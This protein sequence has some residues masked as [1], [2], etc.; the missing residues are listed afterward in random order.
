MVEKDQAAV[1]VIPKRI[2]NM[3]GE[4]GNFEG[5]LLTQRRVPF[6]DW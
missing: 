6:I 4:Q 5:R 2:W 3:D 1:L